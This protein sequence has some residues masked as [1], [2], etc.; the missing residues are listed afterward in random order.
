[1][2]SAQQAALH[3]SFESLLPGFSSEKPCFPNRM[4][5]V[6]SEKNRILRFAGRYGFCVSFSDK[7]K[8]C[9]RRDLNPYGVLHT[10]LKRA[11]LP[12]PPLPHIGPHPAGCS[13]DGRYYSTIGGV[14][15]GESVTK[16]ISFSSV[17]N[18]FPRI[19]S[20]LFTGEKRIMLTEKGKTFRTQ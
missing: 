15:Q 20:L 2:K 4:R 14:C 11:R 16:S 1:M 6:L 13:A 12:V 7:I 10:P 18:R 19:F 3:Q 17:F 9:G 5:L 8:K